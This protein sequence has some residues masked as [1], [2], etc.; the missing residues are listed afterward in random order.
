[1]RWVSI[2]QAPQLSAVLRALSNCRSDAQQTIVFENGALTLATCSQ[3][4]LLGFIYG[5]HLAR[6]SSQ[7]REAFSC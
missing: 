2:N 6:R 7:N 1:M 5:I 4:W 3:C